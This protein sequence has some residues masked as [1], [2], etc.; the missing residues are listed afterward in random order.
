MNEAVRPWKKFN[1]RTEAENASY[2]AHVETAD[3]YLLGKILDHGNGFLNGLVV[4]GGQLYH[5][6][7]VNI[8]LD[9]RLIHDAANI[10]SPWADDIPDL[11]LFNLK[12]DDSRCMTG[13]ILAGLFNRLLHFPQNVEPSFPGLAENAV[14]DF[15]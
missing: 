7:I 9:P 10:L 1:N 8:H 5:S 6:R 12:G 15:L 14:H 3:L 11:L 4:R 2:L 13:K